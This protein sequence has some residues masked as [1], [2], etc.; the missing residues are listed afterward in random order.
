MDTAT[1]PEKILNINNQDLEWSDPTELS[2]YRCEYTGHYLREYQYK[3][4]K[5]PLNRRA[6]L[7]QVKEFKEAK[8][9]NRNKYQ[10]KRTAA[11]KNQNKLTP[12]SYA[13][14]AENNTNHDYNNH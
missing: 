9:N 11:I 10:N 1:S 2:C 12:T 14:A 13:E 5:R 7:R 3:S 4:N 8:F 6:Y